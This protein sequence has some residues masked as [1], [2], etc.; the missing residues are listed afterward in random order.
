MLQFE[1]RLRIE[2]LTVPW[3]EHEGRGPGWGGPERMNRVFG[4]QGSGQMTEA[5]LLA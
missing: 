3:D 5:S 4:D 1:N 2:L